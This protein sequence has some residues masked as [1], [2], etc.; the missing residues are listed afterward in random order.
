MGDGSDN[1]CGW[2]VKKRESRER[3]GERKNYLKKEK[4]KEYINGIVGKKVGN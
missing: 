3:N 2:L 4:E 1:L